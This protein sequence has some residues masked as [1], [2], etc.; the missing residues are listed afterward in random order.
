[1]AQIEDFP[2]DE[3]AFIPADNESGPS[4]EGYPAAV[5]PSRKAFAEVLVQFLSQELEET[6]NEDLPSEL[7]LLR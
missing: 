5:I 3:V 6:T 2:G 1:M 7:E 4:S